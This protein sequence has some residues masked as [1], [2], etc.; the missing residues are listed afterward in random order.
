MFGFQACPA[1]SLTATQ[2]Y[3]GLPVQNRGWLNKSWTKSAK[4]RRYLNLDSGAVDLRRLNARSRILLDHELGPCE[5]RKTAA[6]RH[7][8]IESSAFDHLSVVEH[9]DSRGV[10]NGRKPVRDHKGRAS[11]HH[12]VE[13]GV[14]L[15]LGDGIE[16]AGRLIE[17]QD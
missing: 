1:P 15:G 8:F 5:C 6:F 12:L 16:R 11:L 3:T 14:N 7:Q 13:C 17:D 9:Q 4:F 2:T 10:A